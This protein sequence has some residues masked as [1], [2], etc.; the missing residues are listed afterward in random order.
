MMLASPLIAAVAMLV[1]GSMLFFFLGQEPLHA[2]Y[3][4]FI[5]PWTTRTA[6]ASCCSRR[7]R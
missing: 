3:V 2:F 6:W 1:T 7:R 4:Y 5:K